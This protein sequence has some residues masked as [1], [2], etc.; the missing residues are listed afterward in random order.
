MFIHIWWCWWWSIMN[1]IICM[2]VCVVRL[3]FF[4]LFYFFDAS[5]N[6][7]ALKL[8]I[9]MEAESCT[10]TACLL[11]S[12]YHWYTFFFPFFLFLYQFPLFSGNIQWIHHCHHLHHRFAHVRLFFFYYF[13]PTWYTKKSHPCTRVSFAYLLGMFFSCVD[14]WGG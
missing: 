5:I 2:Y 14:N 9:V 1:I 10:M 11:E 7:I 13:L 6:A 12:R 4:R 3:F 8:G